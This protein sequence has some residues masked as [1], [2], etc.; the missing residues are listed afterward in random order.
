MTSS[1]DPITFGVV[2]YVVFSGMLV[3]STLTGIYHGFAK[4]GQHSTSRYLLADKTMHFVPVAMSILVSFSSP[5]STLGTPAE[6]YIHG[7]KYS[8]SFLSYLWCLPMV[9]Y[10]FL[11]VFH[12]LQ[13]RSAYE[14]MEVRF[15]YPLRIMVTIIFMIQSAAYMSACLVGPAIAIEAVQKFEVWK[16]ILLT[17]ILCTVYTACGGMKGVIWTDVFQFFIIIGTLLAVIIMAAVKAGGFIK[18]FEENNENERLDIFSFDLD[19]TDRM[20]F[21]SGV[22]GGGISIAPM[23]LSQTAVQRYMTVKSLKQSQASV[24][25]N[26]L[27]LS[28]TSPCLYFT[29][30]ALYAYYN[31]EMSILQTA[32]NATFSPEMKSM[33][34][35]DTDGV[36]YEPNYNSADQ[37][38]MYFVSSQ[39]GKFDGVQGLFVACLFAGTLSSVSSSLNSLTAVTLEDFIK[40]YRKWQAARQGKSMYDNDVMDTRLSK[41]LTCAYGIF[42]I[43]LAFVVVGVDSL[44]ALGLSIF[45]VTGGPIMATFAVGMLYKRANGNGMFV[46]TLIGFAFGIWITIGAFANQGT[47]ADEMFALYKISYLMYGFYATV[48]TIVIGVLASEIVR[49][50]VPKEKAKCVD[51]IL[52]ATFM[53]PSGWKVSDS[54]LNKEEQDG[55]I[56]MK[57]LEN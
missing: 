9:A 12:G 24:L 36:Q 15:N 31:N 50:F 38:V 32:I 17:G 14:Y 10:V 3:I 57:N 37:I 22:I 30:L 40:P 27:F 16:T 1:N 18:V 11:P 21:F 54:L 2:D 8:I 56:Q 45:G 51:P 42:G 5:L 53:R 4:G 25:V 28:I 39:F 13:F 33:V 43:G 26:I 35:G 34:S 55:E 19:P 20:N 47:P 23:F 44:L 52:M 7:A 48:A 41:I 6:F 29:G 49:V 46:G